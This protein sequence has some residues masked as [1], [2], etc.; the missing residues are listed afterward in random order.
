MTKILELAVSKASKLSPE[1][2]E[3]LGR[4][5]LERIDSLEALRAEIDLG[6]KELDAG[7]GKPLD[8]EDLLRQART[9]HGRSK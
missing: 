7:L 3:Q 4:E 1:A 2:Q 5:L 8:V 6:V 9:E